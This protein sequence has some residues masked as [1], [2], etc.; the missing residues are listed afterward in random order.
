MENKENELSQEKKPSGLPLPDQPEAEKEEVVL[1]EELHSSLIIGEKD[2]LVLLLKENAPVQLSDALN[3]L[4]NDEVV[5]FYSLTGNDY[6]KLGEIFSYL[7]I[8]KKIALIEHLPKKN[9]INVLQNVSN[10]DLSDF[11]EDVKKQIREKVLSY[12]PN[13]RR[14]QIKELSRYSDDTV[15]SIMTTEF[16]TVQSGAKVQDVLEKIKEIGNTLETVRTIFILDR[17]NKL[18][19][20]ERL[21]D[22]MFEKEEEIIDN[23]MQKDFP[24]ISP[25]A[26][27]EQAVPICEEYD[28]PVLPVVSKTGE[29]LGILTFDDVMDVLEEENT[30]DVL[31]QGAVSPTQRPYMENKIFNIARSYVIWLIALLVINTFSGIIVSRFESALLTLPVLISFVPA[32]NDSTGN[33]G[34]QTTSM[35]IRALTTENVRKKDYWKIIGK[36]CLV[37]IIT[38]L[39]V[40]LFN[41]GWVM[42]ELNTPLL[43]VTDEMKKTLLEDLHFGNLQNGIQY[44]YMVIAAIVSSALFFGIFLS[45]VFASILPLIAKVMHIDPA[46]MSGPLVA[47]LMDIMTLLLYFGIAMAV[48]DSINPGLL[49]M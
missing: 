48:I 43:N 29:M 11:L 8:E 23:V 31:K 12:L 5:L 38:G 32:L 28:L 2:R 33:S 7:Y 45:K 15:G 24:Y 1:D 40:A 42:L 10:D 39:V 6:D 37:G 13:K 47:S 9:L 14:Q 41:F 44:G 21:E 35:V 46:L 36:E 22:M 3:T 27:K 4:S 49:A 16:L 26:D 17:S 25:I 30:E 20:T 34:S 19:G 18:I